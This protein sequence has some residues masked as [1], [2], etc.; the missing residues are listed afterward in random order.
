M[1][2]YFP[3]TSKDGILNEKLVEFQGSDEWSQ[4]LPSF[5][6]LTTIILFALD[7]QKLQLGIWAPQNR[8]SKELLRFS[9]LDRNLVL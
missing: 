4:L 7:R 1:L 5:L 3:G 6:I 8:M 2:L 9:F